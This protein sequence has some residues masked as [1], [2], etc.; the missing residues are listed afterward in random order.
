MRCDRPAYDKIV[1]AS[2]DRLTRCHCSSLIASCRPARSN[3]RNNDFDLII[4]VT[5]KR[6][7]FVWTGYNSIDSCINAQ[8]RQAQHLIV[9]F[10]LNSN[11]AQCLFCRTR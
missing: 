5:T 1:R 6:F 9:D 7:D 11:F 3:S 10:V 2:F 8:F 4:E